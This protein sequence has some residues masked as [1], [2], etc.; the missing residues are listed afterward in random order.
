MEKFKCVNCGQVYTEKQLDDYGVEDCPICHGEMV[1]EEELQAREDLA[2]QI[3]ENKDD[4]MTPEQDMNE[5]V[6]EFIMEGMAKNIK[7][8]GNN[9]TYEF[10]EKIAT[11]ETRIRYRKYFLLVGGQIPEGIGI[12]I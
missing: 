6:E 12:E 11:A 7:E 9:G 8:L 2:R 3:A 4:N 10:I 1:M 5:A